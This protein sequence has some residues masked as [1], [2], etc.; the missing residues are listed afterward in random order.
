MIDRKFEFVAVNPCNGKHYTQHNALILCA[1]DL[2]VIPALEA[3]HEECKRLG[4]DEFHLES[5]ELMIGRI[6]NYQNQNKDKVKVPDTDLDCEIE[7]C[8]GGNV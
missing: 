1:K 5:I 7:R 2:A 8:I 3:Y 4:A 6:A